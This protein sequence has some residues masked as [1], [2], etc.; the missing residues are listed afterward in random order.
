MKATIW[1]ALQKIVGTLF[2]EQKHINGKILSSIVPQLLPPNQPLSHSH[3]LLSSWLS[4]DSFS[5]ET[6]LAPNFIQREF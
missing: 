4:P 6:K 2:G 1:L 5:P 3:G